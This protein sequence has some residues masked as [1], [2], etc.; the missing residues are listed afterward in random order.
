MPDKCL[1]LVGQPAEIQWPAGVRAIVDFLPQHL[2][3]GNRH[4]KP[5]ACRNAGQPDRL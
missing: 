3:L 4:G 2:K 5:L 1:H